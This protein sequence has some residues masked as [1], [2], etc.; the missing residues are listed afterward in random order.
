MKLR[1]KYL[2][3][4][5]VFSASI[6][7]MRTQG[8]LIENKNVLTGFSYTLKY[9]F[10]QPD[11]DHFW[12]FLNHD[13]NF[14]KS[15][16]D[17]E[18]LSK[19]VKKIGPRH[20]Y[21]R[22]V[23]SQKPETIN[24]L[25]FK[26]RMDGR[27]VLCV[28]GV[29]VRNRSVKSDQLIDCTIPARRPENIGT[30]IY[31]FEFHFDQTTATIFELKLQNSRWF[32]TDDR[33]S[34]AAPV[35]N[36][37]MRDAAV[38]RGKDGAWYMTGTTG[39]DTFMLPNPQYWLINPGIQLFRSADLKTWKSLGY[40]WTFEKDGTWN[41]DFGTFGGRGPARGIFAPE[42]KLINDKYWISYSVNHSNKSH[43]HGIGLLWANHPEGPYHEV[44]PESPM[45]EGFDPGLFTDDDQTTYLLKHGGQIVRLKN[46]M[47]GISG[48]FTDLK[49]SNFPSVGYEGVHLFKYQG[50]YFLT[51]ADW[52]IHPDGKI[53]Y[54]SMV[55]TADNIY[56]P[57][58]ERYCALRYGGHNS[59][60]IG[61]NNE[62]YATK[63][64]YSDQNN[65]WQKVSI[66]RMDIDSC[67]FL[68][69][70]NL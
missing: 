58:S 21:L 33:T 50:K 1:M 53:S 18:E 31:A 16:K 29:E 17:L 52:N 11:G 10:N 38:C 44:S 12:R 63:W 56:G 19:L 23:T 42:I 3:V 43:Q 39:D 68:R 13:D 67:G 45:T 37:M 61:E 55:S 25:Y 30:N 34:D 26:I 47:S 59:Y 7:S 22:I 62:L 24:N 51:S 66:I 60:F 69:V 4:L 65:H 32:S 64:C 28:N 70:A 49:P 48:P 6:S 41:K 2:I 9:T 15:V 46:D 14:W 27:F 5:L 40:V 36:V 35:L 57:Y 54:D 8:Q 20:L